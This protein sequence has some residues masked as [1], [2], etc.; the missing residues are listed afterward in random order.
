MDVEMDSEFQRLL[1]LHSAGT[2]VRHAGPYADVQVPSSMDFLSEG[3][4]NKWVVPFYLWGI[5]RPDEFISHYMGVRAEVSADLCRSLLVDFNWRPRIVA[6]YFA[7]IEDLTELEEH[8]GRLFLRSDVCFAGAGY[9][10]ALAMFNTPGS[11][12]FLGKY[13]DHYLREKDLYFDQ[14]SAMAAL[15]FTDQVNG[16]SYFDEYLPLWNEFTKDKPNHNLDR[17]IELFARDVRNVELIQ[18]SVS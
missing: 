17:A 12:A 2:T 6:A 8:I 5:R 10:L 11:V 16:T 1:A 7:A 13:L 9:A 3:M 14:P 18:A 15:R 4:I